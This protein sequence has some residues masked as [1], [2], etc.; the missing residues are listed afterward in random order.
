LGKKEIGIWKDVNGNEICMHTDP[1]KAKDTIRR[2]RELG[3]M[4]DVHLAMAHVDIDELG[5]DYLKALLI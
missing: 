2:L 5:D 3:E 4:K 1:E